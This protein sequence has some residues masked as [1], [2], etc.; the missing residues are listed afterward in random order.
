MIKAQKAGNIFSIVI[1]VLYFAL[2]VDWTQWL[3]ILED[4]VSALFI[5]LPFLILIVSVKQLIYDK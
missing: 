1:V 2:F 3:S 5:V 4:F